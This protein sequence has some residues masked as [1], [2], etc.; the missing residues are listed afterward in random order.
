MFGKL[1]IM[2]DINKGRY[3]IDI[4]KMNIHFNPLVFKKYVVAH[5][6]KT[7]VT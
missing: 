3:N 4:L 7:K 2:F 6:E 5:V 1:K